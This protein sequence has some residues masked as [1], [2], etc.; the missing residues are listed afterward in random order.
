MPGGHGKTWL[1]LHR[2][3]LSFTCYSS[4]QS[5]LY[6]LLCLLA[7]SPIRVTSPTKQTF[8][9]S[10]LP[11]T[12]CTKHP[13]HEGRTRQS[14]HLGYSL[15]LNNMD[16]TPPYDDDILDDENFAPLKRNHACLQCKK[17]KV[18]CDAV[19]LPHTTVEF[20]PSR[21]PDSNISPPS[22]TPQAGSN[23]LPPDPT[24]LLSLP[25]LP[26]PR[27]SFRPTIQVESSTPSLHFCRCR[28]A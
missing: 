18:K 17:R 7:T 12:S 1:F 19:S 16:T 15:S 2:V 20:L 23:R 28:L 4:T 22:I 14:A 21:H 8:A 25:P 5:K 6:I 10:L 3:I 11:S 27:P 9:G 26:R 13:S 24:D